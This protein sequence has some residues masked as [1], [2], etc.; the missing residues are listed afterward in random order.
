MKKGIFII[1][2][3]YLSVLSF[4]SCHKAYTDLSN[5]N[6]NSQ[7]SSSSLAGNWV[8][9]SFVQGTEDK[10]SAFKD[11]VFSF[12][13]TSTNSGG[14]VAS[15]N[16]K[17]IDGTWNYS[18]AVTYYGST[19]KSSMVINLGSSSPFDRLSATWNVDSTTSSTELHLSSP[20][21]SEDEHLVFVKN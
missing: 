19:S 18:P 16:G 3:L 8:M 14:L 4:S 15:K 17:S 10:S 9:S 21:I 1:S 2:A 6:G 13:A 20:E 7:V 5:T 12:N 11:Y